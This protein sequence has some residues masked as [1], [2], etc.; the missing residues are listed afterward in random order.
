MAQDGQPSTGPSVKDSRTNAQKSGDPAPPAAK[1]SKDTLPGVP[2]TSSDPAPFGTRAVPAGPIN[3]PPQDI[4]GGARSA[5]RV[6]GPTRVAPG[7]MFVEGVV[8]K[9]TKTDKDEPNALLR[10]TLDPAQDWTTFVANGPVVQGSRRGSKTTVDDATIEKDKQRLADDKAAGA[11]EAVV[12]GDEAKLALDQS[13]R[14]HQKGDAT[15]AIELSFTRSTRM[16]TF[17]RT[18]DGVDLFGTPTASSPDESSSLSGL[19]RRPASPGASV[20][21][22]ETN[23]TN[24]REGSFVAVRYRRV[25]DYNEVIN[26]S[27]IEFPLGGTTESTAPGKPGQ[28]GINAVTPPRLGPRQPA[29]ATAPARTPRVPTESTGP[30]LPR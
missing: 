18:D 11:D 14:E 24:I 7:V 4:P 2:A 9:I 3:R 1:T 23:L 6:N 16:V 21:P 25:G 12:S 29:D 13:R 26:L 10:F 20:G 22:K 30:G 19:T 28:S 5:A 15:K 8:T 17:A 27:L